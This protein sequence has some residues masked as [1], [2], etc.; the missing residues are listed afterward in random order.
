M[1]GTRDATTQCDAY[2]AMPAVVRKRSGAKKKQRADGDGRVGTVLASLS[3]PERFAVLVDAGR[4]ASAAAGEPASRWLVLGRAGSLAGAESRDLD[5]ALQ[6]ANVVLG[7][8][9]TTVLENNQS[10]VLV[11]DGVALALDGETVEGETL[12]DGVGLEH[13]VETMKTM[14]RNLYGSDGGA[15]VMSK[16]EFVILLDV[17]MKANVSHVSACRASTSARTRSALAKALKFSI[18]KGGWRDKKGETVMGRLAAMHPVGIPDIAAKSGTKMIIFILDLGSGTKAFERAVKRFHLNTDQA[19]V[20]ISIDLDPRTNPT[21]V[22]DITRWR[23]WYPELVA[24]MVKTFPGFTGFF[25]VHFSPE[26]T[27]LCAT[28]AGKSRDTAS[29]LWL[30]LCGAALVTELRP[31]TWT[32]ESSASGA[33]HLDTHSIM[34][35]LRRCKLEALLH[36]CMAIEGLGNY[37]P[38]AWWSNI[39]PEFLVRV[40]QLFSCCGSNKCLFKSWF[41]SHFYVSQMGSRTRQAGRLKGTKQPGMTRNEYMAIPDHM[42]YEFLLASI[43]SHF[44]NLFQHQRR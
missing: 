21:F 41:G 22:R 14:M 6:S 28:K 8:P 23:E 42:A 7:S 38:G 18:N 29:A 16:Q 12:L 10:G 44:P 19:F 4:L 1:R 33:H 35:P 2:R 36:F 25:H 34:R 13:V 9:S 3:R 30:A 11:E 5:E 27:E 24:Y 17:A 15:N 37:K 31:V 39:S 20:V 43:K 26:C 32:L 40:I